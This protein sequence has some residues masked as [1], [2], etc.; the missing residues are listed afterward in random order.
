MDSLPRPAARRSFQRRLDLSALGAFI[1]GLPLALVSGALAYLVGLLGGHR[2]ATWTVL[3]FLAS[4]AVT[5]VPFTEALIARGMLKYR[6]PRTSEASRVDDAW[7]A[8][9]AR[10]DIAPSSYRLWVENI[11]EVN[12]S[13]AAG[14]LIGVTA[15]ALR[16]AD[17]EELE[18]IIAHELGHHLGGHAHVAFLTYWYSIP[19]RLALRL[20]LIVLGVARVLWGAVTGGA[21]ALVA[22]ESGLGAGC[23]VGALLV[24]LGF[25]VILVGGAFIVMNPAVWILLIAA[26]AGAWARRRGEYRADRVAIALGYGPALLRVLSFWEDQGVD[27]QPRTQAQMV[28]SSHPAVRKRIQRVSRQLDA[29][30]EVASSV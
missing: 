16:H 26:M 12:A 21:A 9:A 6:L 2:A 19:A 20:L 24:G 3:G 13:A 22:F 25:I 18:A 23:A 1:A 11:E 27:D 4:G 29:F 10:A 15:G 7:R 8:V 30:A 28:F 14:R 5:F 17:D